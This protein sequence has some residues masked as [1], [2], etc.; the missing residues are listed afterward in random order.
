[1][2]LELS[3]LAKNSVLNTVAVYSEADTRIYLTLSFADEAVCIGPAPSK[4][5]YLKIPFNYFLL[6]KSP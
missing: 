2:P 6:H 5:S 1:M 3:A 4:D